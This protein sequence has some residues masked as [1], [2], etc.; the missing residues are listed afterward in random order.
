M[1]FNNKKIVSLIVLSCFIFG[2]VNT[3]DAFSFKK[4]K[5]N[6][7]QVANTNNAYAKS[8]KK[9]KKNAVEQPPYTTKYILYLRLKI[10]SIM[11]FNIIQAFKL[12]YIT[13]KHI[14]HELLKHGQIISHQ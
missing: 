3:A 7:V 10:V 11:Q 6:N 1:R 5:K 2:T 13:K 9:K 4:N 12:I 14:K 8:V